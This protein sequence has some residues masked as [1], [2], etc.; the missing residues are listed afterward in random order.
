MRTSACSC[1]SS[2]SQG[3]S[4]GQGNSKGNSLSLSCPFALVI[5]ACTLR[6]PGDYSP[7]YPLSQNV[8]STFLIWGWLSQSVS[9]SVLGR[10]PGH[11]ERSFTPRVRL[12]LTY[13]CL[14]TLLCLCDQGRGSRGLNTVLPKRSPAPGSA[15]VSGARD[16]TSRTRRGLIASLPY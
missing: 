13:S 6:D 8:Q 1:C 12:H 4:E 7:R 9:R 10:T 14:P 15:P 16:N 3:N 11:S 5:Y 2:S